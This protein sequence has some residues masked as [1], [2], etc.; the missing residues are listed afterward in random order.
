MYKQA[1]CYVACYKPTPQDL[2]NLQVH[3]I[4]ASDGSWKPSKE[5]ASIIWYHDDK[6]DSNLN[7]YDTWDDVK[8]H[9]LTRKPLQKG[10]NMPASRTKSLPRMVALMLNMCKDA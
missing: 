5:T 4:T 9:M 1:L 8:N 6:T 2:E 3:D 7:D 10:E